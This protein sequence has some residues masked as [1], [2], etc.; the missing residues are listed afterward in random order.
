MEIKTKYDLGQTVWFMNGT[1]PA[2][3]IV[4]YIKLEVDTYS[5]SDLGYQINNE[6]Y[7]VRYSAGSDIIINANKLFESKKALKEYLFGKDK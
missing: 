5:A 7:R 6:Q 3:G 2:E 4:K 1:R